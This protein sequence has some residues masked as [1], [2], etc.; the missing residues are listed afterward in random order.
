MNRILKRPRT[1]EA[2]R[3]KALRNARLSLCGCLGVT[4]LA[5]IAVYVGN[6]VL[7]VIDSILFLVLAYIAIANHRLARKL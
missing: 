3:S 4:V 7:L 1:A 2:I 5:A 6:K